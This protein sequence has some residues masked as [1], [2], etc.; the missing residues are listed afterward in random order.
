MESV[1]A[2]LGNDRD[3]ADRAEL[4]RVVDGIDADF[5]KRFDV[6]GQRPDLRFGHAVAHRG[7][8]DD[9]SGIGWCGCRRIESWNRWTP[10]ERLGTSD[11]WAQM[12]RE[13]KG[14]S[15]S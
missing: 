1:G 7:A 6:V 12:A 9:S 11:N 8:V 10:A 14:M 3:L 13:F 2:A 15:R 4:R 5:L